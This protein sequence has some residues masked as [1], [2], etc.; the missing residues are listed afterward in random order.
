[1]NGIGVDVGLDIDHAVLRHEDAVEEA[2]RTGDSR[3]L[4]STV[5]S[6]NLQFLFARE[7]Q[8]V[9]EVLR[10]AAREMGVLVN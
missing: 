6:D 5:S 1:M 8:N 10:R 2:L 3:S 4:E 9:I 7:N